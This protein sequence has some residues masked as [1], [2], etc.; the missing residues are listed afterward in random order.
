PF[1]WLVEFH[2]ILSGGGFD[3]IIGNPPYVE[4]SKVKRYTGRDYRT[5]R[6]LNLYA[7]TIERTLR[8]SAPAGRNGMIVPISLACSG[9]FE[10][11]RDVL[12]GDDRNLW[13][14]HFSN[15]PGQLFNGAQNRLTIF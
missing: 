8:L 2:R 9:A 12:V 13:L 6:C 15:R 3:A 7:Y 5:E 10:S 1:H 14:S 4:Y 11:L